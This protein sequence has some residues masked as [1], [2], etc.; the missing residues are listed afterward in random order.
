[1]YGYTD[2]AIG[3]SYA[4]NIDEA[5][6]ASIKVIQHWWQSAYSAWEQEE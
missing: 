2:E 1:M 3:L 4:N 5:V 6:I